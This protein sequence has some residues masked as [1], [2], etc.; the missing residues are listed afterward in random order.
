MGDDDGDDDDDNDDD[1]GGGGGGSGIKIAM[2]YWWHIDI[3]SRQV[4]H[5][6]QQHSLVG[7]QAPLSAKALS[8]AGQPWS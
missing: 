8:L 7:C 1:D 2:L 6:T 5:L 3:V 4:L